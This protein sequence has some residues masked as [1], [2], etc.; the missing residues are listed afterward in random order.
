MFF[1]LK[2]VKENKNL[3]ERGLMP[4]LVFSIRKSIPLLQER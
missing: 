2:E 3:N 4:A 1:K